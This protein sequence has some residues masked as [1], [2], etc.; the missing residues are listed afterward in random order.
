MSEIPLLKELA[1]IA[2]AGVLVT[3]LLARLRLPTV[4][5]LLAAGA[6]LGPFGLG[7]VSKVHDI[8]QLAEVGVVLLLFTIG[9]EFSF[10]RLRHI[11]R[12][13]ALG[14]VIQVLSTMAVTAG[15]ALLF[16][17]SLPRAVFFGFVVSLSSTAIVL[18]AMADRGELDAPH[19]RFIVGTLIFQDLCV[20]PMVLLVPV[21]ASGGSAGLVAS[22]IGIAL[23]KA[24]LV[25]VGALLI[26]RLLVPRLLRW[27]DASRS[28]ELFILALL[29]I[30]VGTAWL[31]SLVQLSLALGAFLG[32][33]VIADTEFQHRAMG[34]IIPLRDAF[35]SVFF[36]SLGM[37]FDIR[38]LFEHPLRVGLLLVGFVVGKAALAALSAAFMRFPARAAWLAGIGLAQFGEF[39][40]VLITVGESAGLIDRGSTNELLAAGVLSMFITTLLIRLAPHITAGERLLSGL[41]RL[42]GVRGIEQAEQP[43]KLDQ[44]VLVIGYGIAGK[45]VARALE[46]CGLKYIVL[47]L[48][49]DTVRKA[50]AASEPVYYADATSTEVLKHA[51][52]TTARAVVVLINDPLAVQRVTDT[53]R[54]VAP[55]VP[56]IIRTRYLGERAALESLGASDVVAEEVESSVE[57]LARVL[58]HLEIPR[59][60]IESKIQQAREDLQTSHRKITLPR[61]LLPDHKALADLKIDSMLVTPD[62]HAVGR[63]VKELDI[64]QRTRALIIAVR[65]QETLL[66]HPDPDL[67]FAV[68]DVIYLVGL[69]DAVRQAIDLLQG[70]EPTKRA[71]DS[72]PPT[73]D[74]P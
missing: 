18:R 65:R 7:L 63:T 14:G 2:L 71:A 61:A 54:R 30:C 24:V 39:G 28:R 58:R 27:V 41:T 47:E 34:D 42:L 13:V 23:G 43:E 26:A 36:V 4:A 22:Q 9:L 32:G 69:T 49:A 72:E 44:H 48:N 38:L 52:V 67:P 57:V 51:H 73:T 10:Q 17:E 31:T 1:I 11:F 46:T 12:R 35:V 21:L 5:G 37:L 55:E 59:N 66:D 74:N 6:L 19:G 15:F 40:F 56:L 64:R 53:V 20:V 68:G 33:M 50:R 8:E 62:S 60:L 25:V 3:A 70:I 45:L 29:A 16:G